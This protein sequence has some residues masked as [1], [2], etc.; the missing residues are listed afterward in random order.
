MNSIFNLMRPFKGLLC[1]VL[2]ALLL[3]AAFNSALVGLLSPLMDNVLTERPT[4]TPSRVEQIFGFKKHFDRIKGWVENAGIDISALEQQAKGPDLLNPVPWSIMV[5]IIFVLQAFFDYLGTYTM[6]RVGLKVVVSLRQRL[7]D[8][9]MAMSMSFYKQF[10]TG[11]IL[12]RINSDILRVQQA[13]SIKLGEMIKEGAKSLA[14]FVL[15][16]VI[17]FKLS[18]TLFVLVPMVGLPIAYFTRKIRKNAARSQ[19]Y[20]GLLTSH[21]K[22]VLVGIRVVKSFQR[23]D[24]ESRKLDRENQAFARYALRELRIVALTTPIMGFIGMI[25]ILAFVSYGSIIIQQGVT[26]K[27]DFLF[28]V[29]A[30]YSLYQPIKRM[31]RSNSEIQQA[32]GVMPRIEELISWQSSI[33]EPAS[34]QRFPGYPR[35]DEVSFRDVCFSYTDQAGRAEVLKKINLTVHHG[36]VVA[37]VGSSG[38]G[39]STLV[40]LLPRF[41]DVGSGAITINGLDIR[42]MSKSDL[43]ALVGMVT[44]D[45]ILF[46]D[47][48]ANNIAY[49]VDD[50][51]LAAVEDAARKAYAD[52]FI[53]ALPQGYQTRIGESGD[54]LSGGQRQRICIARAILK[55]APLLILDEATSALDTE[56]EREVQYALEN[57]MKTKTTFVIAHRLS[58]IRQ[59]GDIIVLHEGEVVERGNHE[60]LMTRDGVYRKL[61]LMQE[62]GFG[63]L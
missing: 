24:F 32:V 59:A 35:I 56:S 38:S 31:A 17:N 23:E 15:A 13:I 50:V 58:T 40:S 48:I 61:I 11:E 21:L 27:G 2:L 14:F 29:V 60:G 51:D 42:Q 6:G 39:K 22:E 30:V 63:T 4:N 44:Q 18:L 26:T 49:G 34:P 1:L 7:I 47:T 3:S 33:P 16:F 43:R 55:D 5:M 28:Y 20:L 57:L 53:R 12:T 8:N 9:V 46:D 62:G 52:Q 41:Y 19:G 45:T 10:N 54:T 25:V 36:D 37:L